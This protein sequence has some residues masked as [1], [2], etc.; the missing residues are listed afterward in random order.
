MTKT[1]YWVFVTLSS[2]ELLSE[3]TILGYLWSWQCRW[4]RSVIWTSHSLGNLARTLHTGQQQSEQNCQ[5][6]RCSSLVA[7]QE[8]FPV[9]FEVDVL[10][11]VS[12]SELIQ[13]PSATAMLLCILLIRAKFLRNAN[14]M[15]PKYNGAVKC[16][17][18]PIAFNKVHK[19]RE[20]WREAIM[21]Q[22]PPPPCTLHKIC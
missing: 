8:K 16:I 12:S 4:Q 21:Y 1:K 14:C 11:C 20:K 9:R 17:S 2:K 7:L 5:I 3:L 6:H 13:N 19:T 10:I 15:P 22:Q 18:S